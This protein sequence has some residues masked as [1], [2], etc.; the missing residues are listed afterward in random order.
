M[1]YV[2]GGF[3]FN[4]E[5]VERMKNICVGVGSLFYKLLI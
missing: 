1:P 2:H 5:I 4:S 3:T